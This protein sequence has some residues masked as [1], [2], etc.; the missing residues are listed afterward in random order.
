MMVAYLMVSPILNWSAELAPAVMLS[1]ELA[2]R[3]S[4][5]TSCSGNR[6]RSFRK[7]DA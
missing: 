5:S 6:F 2:M 4:R 7:M 1:V 3:I